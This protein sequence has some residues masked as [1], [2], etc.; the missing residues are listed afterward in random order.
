M[1][2]EFIFKAVPT[3]NRVESLVLVNNAWVEW[4][5]M[6][7]Y[8]SVLQRVACEVVKR[9]FKEKEGLSCCKCLEP[10]C[11]HVWGLY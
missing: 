7:L 1:G 5:G 4:I 6:G 11:T 9:V 8:G 3:L 10:L 2:V